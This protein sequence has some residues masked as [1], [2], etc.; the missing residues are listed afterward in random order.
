MPP[1]TVVLFNLTAVIY[2]LINDTAFGDYLSRPNKRYYLTREDN[3]TGS[4][5]P[6]TIY[7]LA[8]CTP[9]ISQF[10]CQKCLR[11]AYTGLRGSV[12]SLA[13]L[14]SC[15]LRYDL[16]RFYGDGNQTD[17]ATFPQPSAKVPTPSGK[18]TLSS[19]FTISQ[20]KSSRLINAYLSLMEHQLTVNHQ[21]N[22]IFFS[23]SNS[24]R[25]SQGDSHWRFF[26]TS[27][28]ASLYCVFSHL[29]AEHQSSIQG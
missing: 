5:Y 6:Q 7:S 8:Q 21:F 29:E 24:I 9:D 1:S 27:N 2:D 17:N 12:Q 13:Y 18:F 16:R 26:S 3:V 11:Q 23:Q 19:H 25:W 4:S 28:I 22:N 15:Q 10:L 20:V 14:P